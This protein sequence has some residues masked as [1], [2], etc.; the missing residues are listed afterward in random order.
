MKYISLVIAVTLGLS[1]CSSTPDNP[2][3]PRG[4]LFKINGQ[5]SGNSM[6][7]ETKPNQKKA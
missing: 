6:I 5:K 2:S 4:S 1:A 7:Y 3:V